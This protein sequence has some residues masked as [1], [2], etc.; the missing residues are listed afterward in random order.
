[1]IDIYTWLSKLFLNRDMYFLYSFLTKLQVSSST[2]NTISAPNPASDICVLNLV[3][4]KKQNTQPL[5]HISLSRSRIITKT[6]HCPQCFKTVEKH[7]PIYPINPRRNLP[8]LHV[9]KT[10][11]HPKN[12]IPP[13][14]SKRSRF[15]I[16]KP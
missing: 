3:A 2:K 14:Q 7:H 15:E 13:H 10:L 5:I 8:N 9:H 16:Q 4:Y 11:T 1:M 12:Q 6:K